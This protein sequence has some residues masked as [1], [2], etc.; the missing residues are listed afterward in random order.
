MGQKHSRENYSFDVNKNIYG[1]PLQSCRSRRRKNDLSG[2]WDT[3]GKC[4][5]LGGGVHQ[6]CVSN[7]PANFLKQ[8]VNQIGL[9]VE[10]HN[11]IVFV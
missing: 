10:I 3:D 9:V 1:Q 8:P 4:S 11:H 6:I 2:S 7:I 5:E